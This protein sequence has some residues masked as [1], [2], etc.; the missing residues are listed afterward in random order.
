MH[1]HIRLAAAFEAH[2]I[3]K[4]GIPIF[5]SSKRDP[6]IFFHLAATSAMLP[7]GL[8]YNELRSILFVIQ[9]SQTGRTM[10]R[11]DNGTLH[12]LR[13]KSIADGL[14]HTIDRFQLCHKMQRDLLLLIV[15]GL[16]LMLQRIQI[17]DVYYTRIHELC[18]L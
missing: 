5:I 9:D 15:I 14:Q 2:V 12:F 10:V 13:Q 6:R 3:G 11:N 1:F 8:S 7:F 18:I 17:F 16:A 4:D